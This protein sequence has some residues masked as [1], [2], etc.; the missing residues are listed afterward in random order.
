M[1]C[2]Q[3]AGPD[4]AIFKAFAV[5]LWSLLVCYPEVNLKP[6]PFH[7]VVQLSKF[8]LFDPDQF[9]KCAVSRTSYTD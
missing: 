8:L 4:S 1:E 5:L 9:D 3:R 7:A 2:S 6:M